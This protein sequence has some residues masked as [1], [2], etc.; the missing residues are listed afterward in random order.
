MRSSILR[1][2][3]KTKLQTC[4]SAPVKAASPFFRSR[5]M[6]TGIPSE[7]AQVQKNAEN[8]QA[9][10]TP[11]SADLNIENTNIKTAVGVTLDEQQKVLV[12]SV[13]DVKSI[14]I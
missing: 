7:T 8:Q 4:T 12:G 2:L 1:S 3:A 11:S 5:N 10:G 6:S 13:L 14:D 9:A